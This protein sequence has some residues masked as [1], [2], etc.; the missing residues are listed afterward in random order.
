MDWYTLEE[1]SP[2]NYGFYFL[3][4]LNRKKSSKIFVKCFVSSKSSKYL[5][6][7]EHPYSL[8]I[9]PIKEKLQLSFYKKM[10]K[11]TIFQHKADKLL[12]LQNIQ[13]IIE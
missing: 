1:I 11:S 6:N 12:T 2:E 4:D 10:M 9:G 7:M 8:L 13:E 3:V 5:I